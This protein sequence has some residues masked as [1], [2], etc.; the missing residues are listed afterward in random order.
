MNGKRPAKNKEENC[1]HAM[2]FPI[3]TATSRRSNI[4]FHSVG[5]GEIVEV[6][7]IISDRSIFNGLQQPNV[8]VLQAYWLRMCRR[9]MFVVEVGLHPV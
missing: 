9:R 7:D 6:W 1:N 5:V 4:C 3:E 8:S 2:F